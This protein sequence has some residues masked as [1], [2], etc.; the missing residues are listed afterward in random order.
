MAYMFGILEFEKGAAQDVAD[1][2]LQCA[3]FFP[4]MSTYRHEMKS[5]E[6]IIEIGQSL[7]G[8]LSREATG[9]D[10]WFSTAYKAMS[11]AFVQAM[12]ILRSTCPR[13][14]SSPTVR[15]G[16]HAMNTDARAREI[17]KTMGE[18]EQIIFAG[19]SPFSDTS[20]Q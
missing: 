14:M 6:Y 10:D 8:D 15:S 18:L 9:K 12:L 17:G 16:G 19:L 7:Y 20:I 5:H 13:L 2:C 11:Q 3:A 1:K 4:E